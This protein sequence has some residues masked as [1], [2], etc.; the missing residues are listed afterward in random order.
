MENAHT[1]ND[2]RQYQA[3]PLPVKIAMTK[4]RI[5]AWVNEYGS[6]GV[7]VSFSGGKD[8]TVLLHIVRELYPDIPGVF[9][10]T[11]LEFPE[12]R[13]FVR[14]FDNIVWLRP[15]MNFRAVL[16]KY[17]YPIIS[18]DV[19]QC[20]NEINTQSIR[21]ECD[22]RETWRYKKDF[23]PE[24]D[25]CKRYPGYSKAKYD[26]LVDAP[27]KCSNNCCN[28]MK[29]NPAKEYEK[30]SGRH[31]ILA[32]MA[33]ESRL[34]QTQWLR[35]GCNAF[36]VK[37]PTSKPMSFWMEQDVLQYIKENN[38]PIASVY[39][40]I[41]FD[42]GEELP[43]QM[44]IA[45]LGLASEVRKLKTTGQK[46]TGCMFCLFGCSN[47]EWDNLVRMK[48]THPKQYDYIM[49]SKDKG[50]LDYKNIIDWINEHGNMNIK[51]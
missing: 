17:G 4:T 39:G 25:Y 10:D 8:S 3:M 37:R 6:D 19:A 43:G 18:K 36:D 11:G 13:D 50:G 33:Q 5:R 51:Y 30:E 40:S 15:K 41:E 24:S 12:I 7:Y 1:M 47:P 29:K 38:L 46:R 9:V 14:T 22:K 16:E 35:D 27:F 48:Q 28:I 31:V 42:D 2:L 23:D 20:L 49:R 32:T 26:F 45:E 34:R 44:D 21:N